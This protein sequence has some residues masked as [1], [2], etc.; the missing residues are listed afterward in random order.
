MEKRKIKTCNA[1]KLYIYLVLGGAQ[2]NASY[3]SVYNIEL[4]NSWLEVLKGYIS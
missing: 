4:L 2:H 3:K 1:F